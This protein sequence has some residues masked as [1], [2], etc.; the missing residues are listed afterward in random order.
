MDSGLE[1]TVL[2]PDAFMDVWFGML[3]EM[4]VAAGQPV[5][6]IDASRRRHAF[7]AERDVAAFA[8]AAVHSPAAKNALVDIG[9]PEAITFRDAVAAYE[10]ALGRPIPLRSIADARLLGRVA[11]GHYGHEHVLR[12]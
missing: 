5:T 12:R 4:P 9:G 10:Q 7:V 11:D 2:R 6:L 3:I 8:I 1:W